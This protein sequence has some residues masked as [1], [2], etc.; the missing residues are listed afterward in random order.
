MKQSVLASYVKESVKLQRLFK[1]RDVC[2]TQ[3]SGVPK[4]RL[5]K[6]VYGR[7]PIT[8]APRMILMDTWEMLQHV[9]LPRK[10][11]MVT[12]FGV[13]RLISNISMSCVALAWSFLRNKNQRKGHDR[14]GH[15]A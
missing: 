9:K 10:S 1:A 3:N 2:S 6:V 15:V 8:H 12:V 11:L 14:V 4:I 5:L 7:K 13:N